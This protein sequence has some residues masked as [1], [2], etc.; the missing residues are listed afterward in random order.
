MQKQKM[1]EA[2]QGL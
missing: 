2:A 1:S